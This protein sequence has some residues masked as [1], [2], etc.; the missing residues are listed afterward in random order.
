MLTKFWI[1]TFIK[2]DLNTW[3]NGRG[4][5]LKK[6]LGNC[7][8]IYMHLS[9]P[10]PST[11]SIQVGLLL[12]PPVG[13]TSEGDSVGAPDPNPLPGQGP[14][15]PAAP[16]II[17]ATRR[18]SA[19]S[20]G[21]PHPRPPVLQ[22]PPRLAGTSVW[23]EILLME[24]LVKH[25][26]TTLD[27]TNPKLETGF[28]NIQDFKL[29]P[30]FLAMEK[31]LKDIG[32]NI[33]KNESIVKEFVILGFPGDPALQYFLFMLL[34]IT[35]LVTL[36]SNFAIITIVWSETHLQT[37]MY[38]Y[39]R[40]FSLLE[41]CYVS[42]TVPKILSTITQYGR[43]ISFP[44]CITQLFFFFFFGSTECFLLGV[45]AFDRYLAICHPLR[46]SALMSSST[47][48]NLTLLAWL[49]GF[50][51]TFPPVLSISQLSF[52][53]SNFIN[54]FFC[55]VPPLLKLTCDDTFT[56][57]VLGFI[58]SIMVILTSFF[59]TFT[60]YLYIILTVLKIPTT[61][62]KKKAFSTCSSHFIVV[63]FFY[64][65]IMFMYVR[66][67]MSYIFTLNR[68]VAVFYTVITP[69]LNPMIY[70]LRNKAVKESFRKKM[71]LFNGLH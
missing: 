30:Q 11:R 50:F 3:C 14:L 27:E 31:K 28:K 16:S 52:C 37:P 5:D 4:T 35:Y 17:L 20:R 18:G 32:I 55:D 53:G 64:C 63:I 33:L 22:C 1:L 71:S 66:P 34:F 57:E 13:R 65:S 48:Q 62:G 23:Q 67:K 15:P 43:R 24:L 46:Y 19:P 2:E 54:H 60:S 45:I 68:V 10:K 69:I 36:L 39:L 7:S 42:A 9:R 59:A 44:S 26:Q 58:C 25:E 29:D 61:N 21:R 70:C 8:K 6:T 47:C 41:I 38:F 51:I 56:S 49:S 12:H 40:N